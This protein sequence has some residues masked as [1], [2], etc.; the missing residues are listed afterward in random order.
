MKAE[1]GG[2]TVTLT[3]SVDEADGLED[4]LL[5]VGSDNTRAIN[6]WEALNA[7]SGR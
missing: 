6:A 3:M 7:L 2:R 5:W 4:E 1:R